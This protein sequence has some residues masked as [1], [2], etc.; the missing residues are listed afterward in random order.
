MRVTLL[1][2]FVC[3]RLEYITLLQEPCFSFRLPPQPHATMA[4]KYPQFEPYGDKLIRWMEKA[5]EPGCPIPKT[6]LNALTLPQP[7]DWHIEHEREWLTPDRIASIVGLGLPVGELIPHDLYPTESP[8]VRHSIIK[9]RIGITALVGTVGPGVLF[10]YSIRRYHGSNDPYVSELAKIAY[11]TH[12]PLDTVRYIFMNDVLEPAT[13]PFIEEQIYPSREGLKYRSAE[14]QTWDS[15][16]PEFSAIMGTPIGK[17][18]GSFILGAFGQGV[19]RVAR[20][21]TFQ[22]GLDLHKLDIRF[23]IEDV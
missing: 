11:E 20:I 8:C 13:E 3:A 2:V 9:S 21:V 12:Y 17:V 7:A 14:P 22:S 10:V 23:D 16:A 5:T 15:P 19:K 4:F 18:V 1:L 6:T